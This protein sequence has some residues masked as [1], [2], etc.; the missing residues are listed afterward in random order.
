MLRVLAAPSV[1]P[2]PPPALTAPIATVIDERREL[3]VRDRRGGDPERR[4]LD[5]MRPLLVVEDERLAGIGTERERASGDNGVAPTKLWIDGWRCGGRIKRRRPRI[6]K[7]VDDRRQVLRMH[8]LVLRGQRVEIRLV[9]TR[10]A[11]F[12]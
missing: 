12:E 7:G 9:A 10:L 3:H 8:V 1:P 6:A 11:R 5:G 2:A 4:H